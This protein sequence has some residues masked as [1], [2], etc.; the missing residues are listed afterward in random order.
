MQR[1]CTYI[2]SKEFRRAKIN[3]FRKSHRIYKQIEVPVHKDWCGNKLNRH[4]SLLFTRTVRIAFLKTLTK[5]RKILW[6][7]ERFFLLLW[8]YFPRTV[9]WNSFIHHASSASLPHLPFISWVLQYYPKN[10]MKVLVI[11]LMVLTAKSWLTALEHKNKL[12]WPYIF[13]PGNKRKKV[14]QR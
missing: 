1:S 11:C 10:A 3:Y 6:Y 12:K 7:P 8:Y 4:F 13:V 5:H 14:I 2:W 9:L